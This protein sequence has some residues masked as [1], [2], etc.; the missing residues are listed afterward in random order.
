MKRPG[1]TYKYRFLL[2]SSITSCEV[3]V[4]FSDLGKCSSILGWHRVDTQIGS[5]FSQDSSIF[6]FLYFLQPEKW[7]KKF[8]CNFSNESPT[9]RHRIP[10][11]SDIF[12]PS[13]FHRLWNVLIVN[14]MCESNLTHQCTVCVCVCVCVCEVLVVNVKANNTPKWDCT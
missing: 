13:S 5:D 4:A 10:E 1:Y 7:G 14:A 9:L 8:P 2:H 3:W 11:D 6:K 12:P